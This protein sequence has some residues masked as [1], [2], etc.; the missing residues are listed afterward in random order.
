MALSAAIRK[1]WMSASIVCLLVAS[2]IV[3][4]PIS[5]HADPGCQN[6]GAL[7]VYARGS[8]SGLDPGFNS[9]EANAFRDKISRA[10]NSLSVTTHGFVQLC[11]EDGNGVLQNGE[12]PAVGGPNWLAFQL[13]DGTWQ[14][15]GYGKSVE[16]GTNGLISYLNSRVQR[17]PG[18]AIV[19][20]GFSQGADVVG[21]ALQRTGYGALNAE[22]RRHIA[23]V[24]LYGDP[25]FDSG[26]PY[27]SAAGNRSWWVRGNAR[28][29]SDIEGALVAQNGLL[30]ARNP[31]APADFRGRFGSWCDQNDSVCNG[32]DGLGGSH[33]YVYGSSWI[34]NSASEIAHAVVNRLALIS[35]P[36]GAGVGSS[37]YAGSDT[38]AMNVPLYRGQY[39]ASVDGQY[40]LYFQPDGN[41]VVY[42]YRFRPMWASNTPGAPGN[43][44]VVQPDGNIVM[45][46]SSGQ[47]VWTNWKVGTSSGSRL[48][49]QPDG[50]LV[51][52]NAS[53]QP[54]WYTGTGQ[55]VPV[56]SSF[57]S[58]H[59]S[60][61]QALWRNQYLRSGDGTHYLLLQGDGNLVLYGAG[62]HLL[63]HSG[64][65]GSG[66][67]QLILQPDGNLVLYTAN[68][69]PVWSTNT[70][71]APSHFDV[72]SDGNLVM[73]DP[74][75]NAQWWSGTSGQI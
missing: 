73:Y 35:P 48:V 58:D 26:N 51:E 47:V 45:Y 2:A 28:G 39:L 62:Q 21:W 18:E 20:G 12:Y 19:L 57:S 55:N 5:A 10:L 36:Q 3:G 63:W 50:N 29:Y 66:A 4:A 60:V 41:L 25:R 59:L 56:L 9:N 52:Y 30:G 44:V 61:G 23:F 75:G 11:D 6:G 49:I 70:R 32:T 46:S 53:G 24:A 38:I 65:G 43:F 31:Y 54:T 14:Y 15:H 37:G 27:D 42:G 33:A 71:V 1:W 67:T 72:Q 22:T 13:N 7:L 17:C 16:I 68:G 74:A 40:V 64:T 69:Q 8:R 34:S